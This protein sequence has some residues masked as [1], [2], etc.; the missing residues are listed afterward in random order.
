MSVSIAEQK[1]R[2][3]EKYAGSPNT[4]RTPKVGQNGF[5]HYWLDEKGQ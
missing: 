5:S 1:N 3:K 2:L 4:G